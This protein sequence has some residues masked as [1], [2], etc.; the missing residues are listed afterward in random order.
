MEDETVMNVCPEC[1]GSGEVFE[2]ECPYCNGTGLDPK[3]DDGKGS[4]P[5]NNGYHQSL[6]DGPDDNDE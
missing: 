4:G 2:C 5:I 3:P 6:G 1:E